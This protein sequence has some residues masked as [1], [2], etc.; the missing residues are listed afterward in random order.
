MTTEDLG[1]LF[2]MLYDCANFSS[3]AMLA[4]PN[5][6]FTPTECRQMLELMSANDLERLLQGGIPPDA[7]ISH[8]NGWDGQTMHGDAGI[9]YSPT[10]TT[11]SSP[12]SSGK[13]A[14]SSVSEIAWPLI[15]EISRATWKSFQPRGAA[16]RPPRRPPHLRS[17]LRGTYLPPYGAV[18]LNN[19]NAW[20]GG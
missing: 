13:I 3:G 10:A 4:F 19:I 7:R 12:S 11:T 5:G 1:T 2:A 14:T 18:D 15:E 17:R 9:V 8:K 6:E 20:R 16:P